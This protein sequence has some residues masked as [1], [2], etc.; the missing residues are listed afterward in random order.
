MASLDGHHAIVTGGGRGIGRAVARALSA[1]GA[2]V[3]VVGRHEAALADAAAAG[4]A[5]GYVIADVTDARALRQEIERAA[6]LRGPIAIMVA[7]AGAAE[8]APFARS[9]DEL[10]RRMLDLNLMGV[11]HAAHA[12]L[13]GMTARGFGRIVAVASTAGLKGYPYAT[14]YCAAKHAVVGLVRALA[15]ETARTG[16]TVNA[17]CPGYT[18]TD[19]VQQG[20]DRIADKTGRPREEA[21]AAMIKDNP[22]G[23]LIRPEEVAAAVLALCA[24]DASAI[25]GET[26]AIAGGE[27]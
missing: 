16:V 20:L 17:V 12:V 4:D 3:T 25:T 27:I 19:L 13:A 11:V 18:D 1:A 24:P 6:A 14:A 21:L 15:L 26:L 7:N 2:A 9:D 8:S 10:F 23:R 5:A 22:L